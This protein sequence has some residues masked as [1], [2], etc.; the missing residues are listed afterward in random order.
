MFQGFNE[1][2]IIYY[3]AICKENCKKV[4][5]DNEQPYLEGVRFPRRIMMHVSVVKHIVFCFP[6]FCP[7][8]G[9][10]TKPIR[11]IVWEKWHPLI[12]QVPPISLELV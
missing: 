6:C 8:E 1:S 2:T 11:W 3:T 5:Q 7:Y 9:S 10:V 12:Q 4:Y